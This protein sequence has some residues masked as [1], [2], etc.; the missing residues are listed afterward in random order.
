MGADHLGDQIKEYQM[1]GIGGM[2][3][4]DEKCI[5]SF[6]GKTWRKEV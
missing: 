2:Y 6:G 1:S 5:Q 4:R 3:A